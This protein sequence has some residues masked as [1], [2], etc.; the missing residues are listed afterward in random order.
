[1]G[2]GVCG[3]WEWGIRGAPKMCA[4]QLAALLRLVAE[5]E[6]RLQ[7][8][9]AIIASSMPCHHCQFHALSSLPVPCPVI[10]RFMDRCRIDRVVHSRGVASGAEHP[11]TH[12]AGPFYP[13]PACLISQSICPRWLLPPYPFCPCPCQPLSGPFLR[14]TIHLCQTHLAV[15]ALRG[16][17]TVM[18]PLS[19]IPPAV[20]ASSPSSP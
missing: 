17:L 10:A 13:L 7:P 20:L 6:L 2:Y 4:A 14:G 18:L 8:R 11:G 9:A 5:R 16:I 3:I 15:S 19:L 1:M 12:S